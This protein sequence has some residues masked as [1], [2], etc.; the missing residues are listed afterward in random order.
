MKRISFAIILII[1][2]LTGASIASAIES[3]NTSEA[4]THSTTTVEF[5]AGDGSSHMWYGIVAMIKREAPEL[6]SRDIIAQW[7]AGASLAEI[8][9]AHD[10]DPDAILET[11]TSQTARQIKRSVAT[12][13]MSQ[14]KADQRQQHIFE[15]V[16]WAL[17]I[18][19]AQN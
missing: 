2:A 11:I 15:L 19:P 5:T 4:P 12:G 10:I 9:T 17:H 14:E 1:V 3:G 13:G 7:E 18:T 6:E 8:A 16:T